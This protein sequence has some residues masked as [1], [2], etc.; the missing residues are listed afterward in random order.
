MRSLTAGAL[1]SL[2]LTLGVSAC[3]STDDPIDAIDDVPTSIDESSVAYGYFGSVQLAQGNTLNQVIQN[4]DSSA[5]V[6]VTGTPDGVSVS[7]IDDADGTT[8]LEL[9]VSDDAEPGAHAVTFEIAGEPEPVAWT[10]Q[11]TQ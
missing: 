1:L 10:I 5:D 2:V 9:K 3:S 8:R 6:A 11:I 7:I 4:V